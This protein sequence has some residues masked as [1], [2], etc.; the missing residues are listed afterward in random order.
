MQF[1]INQN[2]LDFKFGSRIAYMYLPKFYKFFI[3]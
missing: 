2:F 3:F 1:L